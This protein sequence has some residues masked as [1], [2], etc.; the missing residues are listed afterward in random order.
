M[1]EIEVKAEIIL[2]IN[3]ETEYV[4]AYSRCTDNNVE[5]RAFL[6]E[7]IEDNNKTIKLLGQYLEKTFWS[8][9]EA[10]YRENY[11]EKK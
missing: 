8:G 10:F 2:R 11:W 5:C 4:I 1:T 7:K 3:R 9:W 6:K